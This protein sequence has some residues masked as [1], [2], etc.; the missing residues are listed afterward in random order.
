MLAPIEKMQGLNAVR[1]D[2]K[3]AELVEGLEDNGMRLLRLINDILDLVRMDSGDMPMR[4]ERF[5]PLTFIDGLGRNLQPMADRKRISLH[6]HA[7]CAEDEE[8]YLDRDRL[9][10]VVL[11]LA[12]NGLKFTPSGGEVS[13]SVELKNGQL[14]LK[15]VDN[16]AGMKE[17]QVNSAFE[18]FWQADTSAAK[19]HNGVGIG[20][21]LVK[22]LT[23][24][25]D[26]T[27]TIESEYGKGTAFTISVP[28]L[29]IPGT[30]EPI[31]AGDEDPLSE[32]HNKARIQGALGS[33]ES[34][35]ASSAGP[36]VS[37]GS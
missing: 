16:G 8:V 7:G 14:I 21:A 23:E 35:V 15:V 34:R 17:D 13:L 9:E 27:V 36:F 25:M 4:P 31:P 19:K 6:W 29:P 26:G 3:I 2:A 33:R 1:N 28:L 30:S 11:N 37:V 32:I 24:S 10:K 12:V 20:L 5:R 22:S 18:R